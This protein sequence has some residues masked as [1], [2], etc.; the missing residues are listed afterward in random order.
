MAVGGAGDVAR[1]AR[2]GALVRAA[3]EIRQEGTF[4]FAA[5]AIP[6]AEVNRQ[7]RPKG[8]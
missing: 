3:R 1:S 7:M 2:A 4:G 6:F 8:A 5:Q